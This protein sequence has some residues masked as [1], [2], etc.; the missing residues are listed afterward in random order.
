MRQGLYVLLVMLSMLSCGFVRMTDLAQQQTSIS[1]AAALIKSYVDSRELINVTIV[2][3]HNGRYTI[4]S[5]IWA[6]P[7]SVRLLTHVT[8]M[9]GG[10]KDA[11]INLEKKTFYLS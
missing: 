2:N 11:T 5:S 3:S 10:T 1:K 9:T 7:D 6:G 8:D 4:T